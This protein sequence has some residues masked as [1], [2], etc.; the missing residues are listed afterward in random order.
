MRKTIKKQIAIIFLLMLATVANAMPIAVTYNNV[1]EVTDNTI[2]DLVSY[3]QSIVNIRI[4]SDIS[5]YNVANS[6]TANLFSGGYAQTILALG[7]ATVNV[8]GGSNT[9]LALTGQTN[10]NIYSGEFIYFHLYDDSLAHIY[11]S[12]FAYSSSGRLSGI[13]ADGTSFDFSA[14]Y[15]GTSNLSDPSYNPSDLI[16]RLTPTPGIPG[17]SYYSL[18]SNIVLHTVP[19]P[20]SIV[21]MISGIIALVSM[22]GERYWSQKTLSVA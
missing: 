14:I 4:G 11:G 1:L 22:A 9:L 21:L 15:A 5:A 8:F 18:P 12:N 10:A 6:S 7:E 16:T 19:L 17:V 20:T 2:D 13:W 3:H